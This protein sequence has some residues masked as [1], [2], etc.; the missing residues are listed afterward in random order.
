MT[1]LGYLAQ[2][3]IFVTSAALSLFLVP[4]AMRVAVRREMVDRPG[5]RKTQAAP[6]PYLGGAAI[7]AAF[8]LTITIASLL[9]P[10]TSGLGELLLILGLAVALALLG[11]VD[12]LRGLPAVPRLLAAIAAATGLYL[13]GVGISLVDGGVVDGMLTVVW[14]VGITNAFNFLDNM[15]GASAGIAGVAA[16][17]FFLIAVLNGQFLVAALSAGIAGCAV[18]FLRHNFY[19]ARIY[20]GDAGSVFLGFMISVIAIKL[21]FDAPESV[22]A[23]VPL[24]VLGIPILDMTL[25]VVS[26]L[27]HGRT[28]LTP[29]R[30]HVTHRLVFLGLSVPTA[31]RALYLLGGFLGWAGL[32]MSRLDSTTAFLQLG[33]VATAL[34]VVG[35]AL[36]RVPI[37]SNS[38]RRRV[39]LVEVARHEDDYAHERPQTPPSTA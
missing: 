33:L 6:V 36:Y 17:S 23:F 19:P 4:L 16:G 26:R 12:D 39:M 3:G 15:D 31:V 8:A 13:S 37:Y 24:L 22:T 2:L 18:G 38:E 30:D 27:R 7:V 25:V 9:R 11:L 29:G 35:I 10:P 34:A 1:G 20:M 32:V 5:G 21:R 28:P 14:I